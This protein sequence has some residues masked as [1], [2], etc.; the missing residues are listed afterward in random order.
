MHAIVRLTLA[1]LLL[2][3][4]AAKP[5]AEAAYRDTK[6]DTYSIAAFDPAR[7]EGHWVQ[8]AGFGSAC[9]GGQMQIGAVTQYAL[10]LPSGTKTG[11][12]AMVATVPG[13]FD[14]P[15]IGPFWVL[16]TDIDNRTM[17]I[18]APSGHY[19]MILNRDAAIP[20]D[21]LNAARDI[22]QFN[23]YDLAKLN[24]Y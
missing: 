21:R 14:L 8:V 10:C 20:A 5:A 12:A 11:K 4:C 23:G 16:W 18:G 1:A 3:A 19:G 13:R 17:V 2:A 15:G 6:R 7:I 22:M 24:V 9:A